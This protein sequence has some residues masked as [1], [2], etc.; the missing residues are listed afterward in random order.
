MRRDLQHGYLKCSEPHKEFI[1]YYINIYLLSLCVLLCNHQLY[2]LTFLEIYLFV[3][4]FKI[5][6]KGSI[7]I[8]FFF[9]NLRVKTYLILTHK[10]SLIMMNTAVI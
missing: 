6:T 5:V 8:F 7:I 9:L 3:N 2:K 10:F 1:N 4:E